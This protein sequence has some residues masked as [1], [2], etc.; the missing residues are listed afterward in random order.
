MSGLEPGT[1]VRV[2]GPGQPDGGWPGE[3]RSIEPAV[4]WIA[5]G[6]VLRA[7]WKQTGRHASEPFSGYWFA[8]MDHPAVRGRD[9]NPEK[10]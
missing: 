9:H 7:F 2:F 10:G 3:V 1:E 4:A 5:S 6:G 8:P